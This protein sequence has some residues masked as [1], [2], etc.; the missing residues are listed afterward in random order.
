MS[1]AGRRGDV[2]AA[3][4]FLAEDVVA[5]EVSGR[6][7]LLDSP[8]VFLGRKALL[9]YYA[10]IVDTFDDYV[11]EVDEFV[12]VGDWVSCRALE[13]KGP[14]EWRP[15]GGAVYH[16]HPLAGREDRRAAPQLREQG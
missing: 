8:S 4:D 1:E 15:C 2:E 11:R 9:G 3:Q 12:D 16:R 14:L 13:G 6:S 7:P 5:T 10:Q